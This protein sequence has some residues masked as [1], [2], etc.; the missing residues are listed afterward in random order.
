MFVLA[1]TK[2]TSSFQLVFQVVIC[3]HMWVLR[4]KFES[5]KRAIHTLNSNLSR[6]VCMDYNFSFTSIFLNSVY[7]LCSYYITKRKDIE[8]IGDMTCRLTF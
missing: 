3:C 6:I 7:I 8:L 2:G 1:E 4:I 5:S